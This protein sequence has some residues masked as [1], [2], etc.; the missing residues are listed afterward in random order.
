MNIVVGVTGGI[1]AYKSVHL[2][3][4]LTKAGH[5]V[6]VVPTEDA[7]RFVGLPTWEAISRHPVTTSVHDDVAKVRHVALGQA[8]DLVIVAPATANSIAKMAAG[9]ADNLLGTT[10]L[11]TE[12]PVLIAPAMH[13][14]MWR[15]PAT[16]ANV[17]TLRER[18]VRV[19]GPADGELAGGDS[20]PGRM[21]EPEE[22]ADAAQA[23]LSPGDLAGLQV[24]VSAGGTREPIDPVRF[25][26]N[27]SSGR[28]GVELAAEAAARGADVTLVTANVSG[29]VLAVAQHPS[30]RVVSVGTAA[31]LS[32][33]M[34]EE[35]SA[36]DV[37]VM[38]AAVADYRPVT[39]AD[40]KLTKESGGVPSIELVENEDILAA[41][42][43]ARR[44][45][46]VVVGFA[47]ETPRDESE[48]LTRARRKQQR[49]GV[50]FLVVNEVG[51]DRGFE[52]AENAVHIL[53]TDGRVAGSASGSK[54]RVAA[55]IWNMIRDR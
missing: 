23:L 2:V 44:P 20:G 40:R 17:A 15:H 26:G 29:D 31:E 22:I 16:R 14:E 30:V 45:G 10:L 4:L 28:Q 12:S 19:V 18:G 1:A 54:R 36:A 34:K 9:L 49:K 27:R 13:A 55:A 51:W 24:V 7:L 11:A 52:S 39:V 43:D 3:R 48:L 6:T 50:D 47:A 21:A 53:G 33:A 37:V 46:Q 35:A 41:L 25:L 32:Q 42:V 5:D 8:A 38:A